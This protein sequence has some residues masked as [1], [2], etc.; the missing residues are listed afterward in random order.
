MFHSKCVSTGHVL[1]TIYTTIS[2]LSGQQEE[3]LKM[4]PM[5]KL[6]KNVNK[7]ALFSEWFLL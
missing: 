7:S 2:I 6:T 1:Y 5:Q 4:L 3:N